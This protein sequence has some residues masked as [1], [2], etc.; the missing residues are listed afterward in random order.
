MK[1]SRNPSVGIVSNQGG[2]ERLIGRVAARL[3]AAHIQLPLEEAHTYWLQI[4]QEHREYW[5]GLA[6]QV[7]LNFNDDNR[8]AMSL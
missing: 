7:V 5:E 4:D 1:A 8:W 2:E 6:Q 3:H